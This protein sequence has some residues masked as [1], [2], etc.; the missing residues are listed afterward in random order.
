[1]LE[2]TKDGVRLHLLIQPGARKSEIVGEHAGKL[3]IK[4]NAPPVDGEAN[5]AVVEFIAELFGVAKKN[6]SLVRGQTSKNK[7]LEISGVSLASAQQVISS[8]FTA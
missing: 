3:K 7:V 4:I 6:V 2:E 5:E 1:M 8:Y